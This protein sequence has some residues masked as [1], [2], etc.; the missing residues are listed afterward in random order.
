MLFF[1]YV[2]SY[3]LLLK[4]Q[5]Y[6]SHW[7]TLWKISMKCF[8]LQRCAGCILEKQDFLFSQSSFFTIWALK[9]MGE[10]HD[11]L[12]LVT[13]FTYVMYTPPPFLPKAPGADVCRL[14]HAPLYLAV[15]SP[16]AEKQS[17]L[18]KKWQWFNEV[19]G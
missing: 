19:H 2:S 5:D 17:S 18:E 4:T 12:S 1:A 3:I 7:K 11:K 10:H 8:L 9:R 6:F 15:N 16:R 14:I 13:A